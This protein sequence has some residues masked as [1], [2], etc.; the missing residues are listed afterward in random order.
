MQ[1]FCGQEY[2][3]MKARRMACKSL[4]GKGVKSGLMVMYVFEKKRIRLL[5]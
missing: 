5:S 3:S 4:K 2:L 1:N